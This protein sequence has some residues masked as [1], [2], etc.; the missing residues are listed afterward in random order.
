MPAATTIEAAKK[1]FFN[2]LPLS[3]FCA[4]VAPAFPVESRV[5]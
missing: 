2:S 4:G 1:M 3:P 5:F